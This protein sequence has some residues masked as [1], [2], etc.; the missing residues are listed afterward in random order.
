[1]LLIDHA[2]HQVIVLDVKML[3]EG[4]R[5][6]FFTARKLKIAK[7]MCLQSPLTKGEFEGYFAFLDCYVDAF[8]VGALGT[9][10]AENEPT[11][12]IIGANARII[13]WLTR[14]CA[15]WSV[16]HTFNKP[17]GGLVVGFSLSG[18]AGADAQAEAR[19]AVAD[20]DEEGTNVSA[21]MGADA[22]AG[23]D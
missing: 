18:Y 4:G 2:D 17:G 7:Y 14:A 16:Y 23:E 12:S 11:L 22:G 21:M 10:D 20:A 1:M 3:W 5:V 15:C 6:T 8:L 13:C 9:W 19:A